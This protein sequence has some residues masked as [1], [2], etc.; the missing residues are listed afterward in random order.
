MSSQNGKKWL[1]FHNLAFFAPTTRVGYERSLQER[2]GVTDPARQKKNFWKRHVCILVTHTSW[3]AK[4]GGRLAP[5]E[6]V[7]CHGRAG[8][9]ALLLGERFVVGPA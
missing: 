8:Q 1:V 9:E 5:P 3:V 4:G 6:Q 2:L 7:Q